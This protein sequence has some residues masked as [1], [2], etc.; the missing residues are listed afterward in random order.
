MKPEEKQIREEELPAFRR[1]PDRP[2]EASLP[3]IIVLKGESWVCPRGR[4][5][6]D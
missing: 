1:V 3:L 6:T 4:G 2:T 5:K